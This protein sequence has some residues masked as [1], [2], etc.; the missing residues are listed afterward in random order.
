MTLLQGE[1]S[2]PCPHRE[3]SGSL[4]NLTDFDELKD[5]DHEDNSCPSEK[6]CPLDSD[7]VP[8]S[9]TVPPHNGGLIGK[10]RY[11]MVTI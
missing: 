4:N 6:T 10:E 7:A 5:K 3:V 1:S 2:M 11:S 8:M 9:P